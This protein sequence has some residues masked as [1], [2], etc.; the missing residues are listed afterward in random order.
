MKLTFT[1]G[2]RSM[3]CVYARLTYVDSD[4]LASGESK[5]TAGAIRTNPLTRSGASAASSNA[6]GAPAECP[7]STTSPNPNLSS[8]ANPC[9]APAAVLYGLLASPSCAHE[10]RR[11]RGDCADEGKDRVEEWWRLRM[12]RYAAAHAVLLRRVEPRRRVR[13]LG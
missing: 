7:T 5:K 4:A 2:M 9:L 1:P 6:T 11:L 3:A 13:R 10:R 12:M 8:S